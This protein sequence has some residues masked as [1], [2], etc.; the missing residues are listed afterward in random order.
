MHAVR[1]IACISVCHTCAE[2]EGEGGTQP[3]G[4]LDQLLAEESQEAA[5]PAPIAAPVDRPAGGAGAG[6]G[7]Q[8]P[9]G[10]AQQQQQ[11]PRQ[12]RQQQQAAP[13]P[14]PPAL[15]PN[16]PTDGP[17][18]DMILRAD[19]DGTEVPLDAPGGWGRA[20]EQSRA[21]RRQ[22]VGCMAVESRS[23]AEG[24]AC[25]GRA[26]HCREVR[27]KIAFDWVRRRLVCVSAED[28]FLELVVP[29]SINKYLRSYQRDGIRFLFRCAC[30]GSGLAAFS[31]HGHG[32]ARQA[33]H[34]HTEWQR[35]CASPL[36]P[37]L[38]LAGSMRGALAACLL[39]TW[40]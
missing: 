20:A 25:G 28:P 18:E 21:Q 26:W 3:G 17:D 2:E 31:L 16:A 36:L 12:Q 13:P 23:A 14:R 5:A 9:H 10:Q 27:H 34:K 1:A 30:K 15:R 39:T 29:A 8:Q 22:R 40:G 37:P 7:G 11:Q 35:L 19:E 32:P 4:L 33:Q 38:L 24:D 6:R